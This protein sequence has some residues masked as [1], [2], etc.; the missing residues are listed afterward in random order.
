[1]SLMTLCM[2]A[3]KSHTHF[4]WTTNGF[5]EKLSIDCHHRVLSRK[6]HYRN[7]LMVSSYSLNQFETT[8]SYGAEQP[9][10]S[11]AVSSAEVF[12]WS[13]ALLTWC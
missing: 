2:Q 9:P 13:H 7:S 12:E 11:V 4:M 5:T 10:V 1:M 8:P 6:T 3:Y